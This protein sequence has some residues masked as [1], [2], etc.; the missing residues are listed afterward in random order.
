MEDAQ[1]QIINKVAS[2][3]LVTFDLE[4]YY[5]PGERVLLDIKDQLYQE[6]ILKE[7]DFREFIRQHNWS[8]YQN[9]FVAITCTAD[10]IVPTWAFMLVAIAL[11]PHAKQ[12]VFGNLEALETEIFK[13]NLREIDWS[14]FE[15][16]KVVVKGCSKVDV[17]VAIYVEATNNLKK[18][19]ASIMF[20]EPCS[21]VP[22]YKKPKN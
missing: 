11:E 21:T 1:D 19:S 6:L 13:K 2:S 22:L 4:H 14:R 9:K 17:P 5:E 18:F 10:A 3:A 12:V 8:N 16:A 15:N 7:K 20:G